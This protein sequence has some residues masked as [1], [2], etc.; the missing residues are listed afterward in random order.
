MMDQNIF[1]QRW[2]VRRAEVVVLLLGAWG[3]VATVRLLPPPAYV[4]ANLTLALLAVVAARAAGL[5]VDDL[6]FA[7]DGVTL[8]RGLL[9]GGGAASIVL[10]V[11]ALGLL[12]PSMRPFFANQRLLS[13]GRR[14][15][16]Y[17]SIVRIPLGTALAEEV[18]F[19]GVLL[20]LLLQ[21]TSTARAVAYTSLWFGAW[22]ILP[23]IANLE[24]YDA[25]IVSRTPVGMIQTLTITVTA[26]SIGGGLFGLLRLR[27]RS[28][29]APVLTHATLNI[30]AFWA[31]RIAASWKG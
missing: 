4:P 18:L 3:N 21:R 5:T 17:E 31:V 9:L 24:G 22:H 16:A 19:R 8:R 15:A 2:T 27:A 1:G 25:E 14:A 11:V 12:T 28:V 7:I 10:G 29:L 23:T 30:A 20:G 26:T 13:L 6:G